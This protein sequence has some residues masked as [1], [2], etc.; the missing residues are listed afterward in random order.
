MTSEEALFAVG[1]ALSEAGVFT[2]KTA[3]VQVSVVPSVTLTNLW[4]S[5]VETSPRDGSWLFA[6]FAPAC[7]DAARPRIRT[8]WGVTL[9]AAE[10][11]RECPVLLESMRLAMI[12]IR[13]GRTESVVAS[14]A[15][16][17]EGEAFAAR[18]TRRERAALA[19]AL[20]TG[21]RAAMYRAFEGTRGLSHGVTG[22]LMDL[23][24]CAYLGSIQL[25][26]AGEPLPMRI[27]AS[28]GPMD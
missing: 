21:N 5:M 18:F 2:F 3:D 11:G 6:R 25:W 12:G 4:V 15:S 22:R 17:A 23:A 14:F 1:T 24:S 13:R 16:M 27:P 26:I 20:S 8:Q 7:V 19:E 28:D 9:D 10:Y